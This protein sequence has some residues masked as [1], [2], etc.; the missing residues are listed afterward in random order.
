M[1]RSRDTDRG[2]LPVRV[3][4][5][6]A[7]VVAGLV[8]A[9]SLAFGAAYGDHR[10]LI[11]CAGGALVGA[12]VA[13][14]ADRLRWRWPV[15]TLT[16]V[17][18][19]LLFGA[20]LAVPSTTVAGVLPSVES[21]RL[22]ALGVVTSWRQLLTV[23]VPV[24]STGALMIPVYL[25][26]IVTS[27]AGVSIA[28]R[29]RRPLWA[30]TAPLA[31]MLVAALF[32]STTPWLPLLSGGAV[33]LGGLCW[34][35]WR[36]RGQG[37]TAGL[38]VRRPIS[39]AVV[40]AAAVAAAML[41]GPQIDV[42]ERYALRTTVEPP[43]DPQEFPSPLVGFRKYF[44]QQHDAVLFTVAG[45]PQGV[46]I[47]LAALDDYNGVTYGT[48]TAS[49]AFV[50]VGDVIDGSGLGRQAT[51]DVTIGDYRGV[52]LP[53]A[54]PLSALTFRSAN[55]TALHEAFRYSAGNA[56]GLVLSG[57]SAGDEYRADVVVVPSAADLDLA[58]T[59]IE[60]VT[61]PAPDA[62]PE[63]VSSMAGRLIEDASTPYERIEA[64]RRGL[65]DQGFL[66][67]GSDGEQPSPS[68]HGADRLTRLL[69]DTQMVGDQ[70]QF[71]PAMAL[72]LRSLGIPARVVMGFAPGQVGPDGVAVVHGAD[73]TAWVEV[74]FEGVGWVTF[75][76]TPDDQS[77]TQEPEPEPEVAQ[78]AQVRQPPPPAEPPQEA[79]TA[80]VDQGDTED[81]DDDQKHED[82]DSLLATL[83]TVGLWVG[84][85]ILLLGLPIATI[86]WLKSRRRRRRRHAPAPVDRISGGW[87]QIV[88]RAIDLGYRSPVAR[89]RSEAARELDRTFGAST[90]LL[91]RRA[92]AGVFG[93]E[94]VE[95]VEAARFWSDVDAALLGL[96]SRQSRLRRW[97][98]SLSPG[99]LRR[100]RR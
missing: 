17:V 56:A 89:T 80:D 48:S 83:A 26:A 38:D 82:T 63:A 72:M 73:A 10:W 61:L 86:L 78:R 8:V 66:S 42:G 77:I 35:S 84:V 12:A 39:A 23:A 41:L 28:G 88:D 40:L 96:N 15:T 75:D 54:G 11:A 68:G 44:K 1:S 59:P 70:E 71:A 5:V 49:G 60:R 30:L 32:G 24:G 47:R 16:V 7:L 3:T 29:T 69:G 76:P 18:A 100:R 36:L 92:D 4:V 34:A 25:A 37:K 45:L 22:L 87:D 52:F 33:A 57:L 50:P 95:E 19:Y 55:G 79:N 43:I 91:A 20:A 93:P 85:P 13:A 27:A 74:P 31:M 9:A 51:I 2:M 53:S 21:V 67:H 6:D 14:V 99:S 46:R 94:D 81:R 98:A 90:V 97:R 58:G 64:I 65:A 62:V